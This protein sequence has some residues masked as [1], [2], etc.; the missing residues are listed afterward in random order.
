MSATR[1]S[2]LRPKV[3]TSRRASRWGPINVFG[4]ADA[5]LLRLFP[6]R[7]CGLNFLFLAGF[8]QHPFRYFFQI[9][10]IF[11]KVFEFLAIHKL[12]GRVQESRLR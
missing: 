5:L 2:E 7:L 1:R 11:V 4:R 12:F 8:I 10:L 6:V 9:P 3:Y